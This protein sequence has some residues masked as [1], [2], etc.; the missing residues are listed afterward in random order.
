M[1]IHKNHV[2]DNKESFF[3][4]YF[5]PAYRVENLTKAYENIQME[6][7]NAK[8]GPDEAINVISSDDESDSEV[9]NSELPMLPPHKFTL[10]NYKNTKRRGRKRKKRF[11]SRDAMPSDRG[12]RPSPPNWQNNKEWVDQIPSF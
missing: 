9:E 10:E 11:R 4:C 6:I 2:F 5:H 3:R 12:T 1:K 8:L 7:P